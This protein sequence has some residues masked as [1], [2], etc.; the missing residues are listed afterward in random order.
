M[1]KPR[2]GTSR[3]GNEIVKDWSSVTAYVVG[4]YVVSS[5]VIYKCTTNNT[6]SLPPSANWSAV[7]TPGQSKGFFYTDRK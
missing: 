3:V 7:T 1:L 4:N 2:L 5:G 6:N